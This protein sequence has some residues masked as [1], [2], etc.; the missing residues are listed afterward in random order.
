MTRGRKQSAMSL[1]RA[2]A[3]KDC[4]R[5]CL[6]KIVSGMCISLKEE[7]GSKIF[8]FL[9]FLGSLRLT[10]LV[11]SIGEEEICFLGFCDW[12][13]IKEEGNFF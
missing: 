10:S 3:T 8:F 4:R 11:F 13:G 5:L 2:R 7:I 12:Y 6:S 1:L 9:F